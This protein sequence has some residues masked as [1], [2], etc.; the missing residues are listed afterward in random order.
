MEERCYL[1]SFTLSNY[2]NFGIRNCFLKGITLSSW[3]VGCKSK[4]VIKWLCKKWI[5]LL[6][7][8]LAGELLIFQQEF[9]FVYQENQK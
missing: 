6:I 2:S 9:M 8:C 3:K 1:S 4:S 5:K 7:Y